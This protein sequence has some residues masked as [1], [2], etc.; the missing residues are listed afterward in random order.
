MS[1]G[2]SAELS[3]VTPAGGVNQFRRDGSLRHLLTL[4][5]LPLPLIESLLDRA[6]SFVR[7]LGKQRPAYSKAAARRD[8]RQSVHGA[9]DSHAR[10]ASSSPPSAWA[11]TL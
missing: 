1:N 11:P 8:G 5:G 6:Q 2:S 10:V 4:E 9:F 7:T 3:L